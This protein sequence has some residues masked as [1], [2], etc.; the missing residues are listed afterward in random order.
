MLDGIFVRS[1]ALPP[2]E[3]GEVWRY[4]GCGRTDGADERVEKLLD[5]CIAESEN[6]CC[7]RVCYRVFT[8]E[9]LFA[10]LGEYAESK[11]VRLRF[12]GAEYGVAFAA[13]TGLAFDRMVGKYSAVSPA[14]ALIAQALGAE[15]IESV[16][17][18]FES[19]AKAESKKRGYECGARFSAGYGDFPLAAQEWFFSA[20]DCPRKIGL[21]LNESLLMTPTKSVTGLLAVK[22]QA[23]V[24]GDDK[25]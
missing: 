7:G 16:C 22:A 4:A 14:K 8:T 18:A 19:R 15:R 21:T 5:E 12:K 11:L 2:V 13:T 25:E 3:R 10:S 1:Y 24:D 20:L 6:A 17:D 9:A 23:R